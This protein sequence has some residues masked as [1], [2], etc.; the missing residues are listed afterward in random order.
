[1]YAHMQVAE[2]GQA[3]LGQ[4]LSRL[5][6]SIQLPECL[7]IMGYLRRIA[8]FSEEELRA[9]FLQVRSILHVHAY[10]LDELGV[11]W[12]HVAGLWKASLL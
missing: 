7:R 4:L 8:A 12:S 2:V 6:A 10:G 11:G 5:K 1:M 3:M 9:Q